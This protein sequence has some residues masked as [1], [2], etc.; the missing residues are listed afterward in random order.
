MERDVAAVTKK[1]LPQR[2]KRLYLLQA[3]AINDELKPYGLARSQWQVLSDVRRA[4]SM[5]QKELQG[6]LQVEPAT[7]TCIVDTL[8]AKGWLER[9]G[10]ETDK[11]VKV[12]RFTA[13]GE[14]RWESIPDVVDIVERR[15]AE[16]VSERDLRALDRVVERMTDNLGRRPAE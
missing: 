2:I 4:G 11:R 8:V 16:G 9:L 13:E 1:R 10:H 7:L 5:T 14:K 15:M 12:V 6:L 3:Q